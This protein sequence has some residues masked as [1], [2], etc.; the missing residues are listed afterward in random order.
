[1]KFRKMTAALALLGMISLLMAGCGSKNGDTADNADA[2]GTG[3]TQG[4][5][6]LPAEDITVVSREDGSG[7][8]GAFVELF[9][10]EEEINGEKVDMTTEE[11]QI[12]N[13]TSV[14]MTTVANDEYAIG[15]ISLGSLSNDVKALAIDG[16]DATADNVK[17]GTY[18]ISRPFMIAVNPDNQNELTKDFINFIL[19]S[20]GQAVVDDNGYI[21]LDTSDAYQANGAEGKLVVGGSSS[22]APVMEKLIEAY[23]A[24]NTNAS[25][26]LQVTDS[27]T[28]M[29]ETANGNYDI[30]MASRDLKDTELEAGLEPQTIAMDGIAVIVNKA[31]LLDGLSSEQVK[32]IYTGEM[33]MWDEVE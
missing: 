15:Y 8:R 11:A 2:N 20:E 12:S 9:G 33:L 21:S 14:V 18:K 13:S 3:A 17:N 1:M 31:N 25:V 7:T 27:T 26:E 5:E 28:G 19:S 24:V 16:T 29:T 30:G 32:G 4:T 23:K 22:V 10:V 6:T